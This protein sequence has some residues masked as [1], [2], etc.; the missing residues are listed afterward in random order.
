MKRFSLAL[1]LAIIVIAAAGLAWRYFPSA[2]V[3]A[4]PLFAATLPDIAGQP[5]PLAQ[6]RG[7]VLLVNFWATWCAPCR[8][9]MPDL[10]AM[11]EDY[12]DKGLHIV[13]IGTDDLAKTREYALHHPVAYPLLAADLQGMTL[14]EALGNTQS[15]LPFSALIDAQ[16]KVVKTYVGRIN[17]GAVEQEVSA[18]LKP[19][20]TPPNKP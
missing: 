15:V 18:L 8:E 2:H 7:Q 6:W 12:K 3:S 19:V 9:E 16:G 10:S 13:G 14:A 5:H 17:R 4:E 1:P 11:A 20:I